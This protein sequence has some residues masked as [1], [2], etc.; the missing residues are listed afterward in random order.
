MK[1][2]VTELTIAGGTAGGQDG[3]PS[4]L[5][6]RGLQ[7]FASDARSRSPRFRATG[8][9]QDG[10]VVGGVMRRLGTMARSRGVLRLMCATPL[11]SCAFSV[12]LPAKRRGCEAR[13]LG[14]SGACPRWRS[15]PTV[16]QAASRLGGRGATVKVWV[17]ASGPCRDI[18]GCPQAGAPPDAA[19]TICS[20]PHGSLPSV[21]VPR[22]SPMHSVRSSLMPRT[23]HVGL[24][25]GVMAPVFT[26]DDAASRAVQ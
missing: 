19:R 16:P 25:D 8:S 9:G 10:P 13:D 2:I 17:S 12:S 6:G 11:A 23:L 20:R 4:A 7:M 15:K 21:A 22:Q 24:T 3:R 26:V 5:V 1:R 14:S 18:E